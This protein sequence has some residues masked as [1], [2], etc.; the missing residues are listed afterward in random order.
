MAISSIRTGTA[1]VCPRIRRSP[2]SRLS[3]FALAVALAVFAPGLLAEVPYDELVAGIQIPQGSYVDTGYVVK[4]APKVTMTCK[5]LSLGSGRDV[6]LFGTLTTHVG[7]FILNADQGSFYL[8]NGTT[9]GTTVANGFTLNESFEIVCDRT[10][11]KNGS[12]LKTVAAGDFSSNTET[13]TF[14][15]RRRP[16]YA[17]T[18]GTFKLE[19]GDK[20]VCDMVACQLGRWRGSPYGSS[21]S[22]VPVGRGR[23]DLRERH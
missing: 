14:P 5:V 9:S 6:D 15:G 12:A 11:I 8:R 10:L 20:L 7:C 17:L 2:L 18:V 1:V 13:L 19:D 21:G 4:S 22:A 23:N 3:S 16:Y